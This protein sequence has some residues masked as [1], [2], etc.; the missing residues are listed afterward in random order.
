MRD[1]R[2]GG[3]QKPIVGVSS[4]DLSTKIPWCL[5]TYKPPATDMFYAEPAAVVEEEAKANDE[6]ADK[7]ATAL[8]AMELL[9]K[10]QGLNS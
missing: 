5:D 7:D 10:R 8:K 1:T 4:I 9:N 3:F 6:L 2:L